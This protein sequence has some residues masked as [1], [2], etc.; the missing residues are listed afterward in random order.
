M[1]AASAM[2]A[3]ATPRSAARAGSGTMISSG[4]S[5]EAEEEMLPRPG[6]VRRSRSSAC[7]ASISRCGSSEASTSCIISPG[8]VLM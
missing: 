3:V 1:R 8:S 2:S 5:K 4:R 7:A 6:I